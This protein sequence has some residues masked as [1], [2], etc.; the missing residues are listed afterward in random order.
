[1]VGH[2]G[3]FEATVKAVETLDQCLEKLY[4]KV[5]EL[6]GILIVTADHGNC[7]TMLDEQNR[8]ITSHSKEPVPFIITKK[9]ITLKQGKL[10]DIAPT[11]LSLLD[12]KIPESMSG[13]NLI[14]K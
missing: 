12:L 3:D 4:N 14:K 9:D 8:I 6:N 10:G 5:K 7:D 11:M 1:M 13:N 2:T